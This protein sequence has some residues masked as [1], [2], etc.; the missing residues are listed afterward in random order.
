MRTYRYLHLDVFTDRALEGNQL[1]VFPE[2]A[3][4]STDDMQRITREMN[5]SECTY[6]FPAEAP[7]TDVRMRIFT[8]GEELPMAGHPTVGSTFALAAEGVI[9]RGRSQFVFGL[10]VGPTPVS[11]DW[12]GDTLDFVWMTQRSPEF[13]GEIKDRATF[14]RALGVGLDD[15]AAAPVQVVSCGVPFL[16]A[17]LA[18]RDA[19]DRVSMDRAGYGSC[20]KAAWLDELPVFVFSTDRTSAA[21]DEAVYS[22][23]L[24]PG[25]GVAEDPATGGASGPLGCYLFRHRLIP[26]DRLS[27]IVS[28][29]GVK[30]LRPS[31]IHISIDAAG[32]DVT[33]VRVG[34]RSVIVGEGR[35]TL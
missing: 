15:L 13:D 18:S 11:L 1:A 5:F 35:L 8:P 7:G 32:E 31:R 6:I 23:M 21:G 4:L 24:A 20:L 33:R 28:L 16:F 34:G 3:G 17:A 14:A 30:M 25:L 29:Q 12:K 2:P 9:A 26:R 27:H 10:G 22:R 19:V